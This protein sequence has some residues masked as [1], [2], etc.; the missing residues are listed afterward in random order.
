MAELRKEQILT[1]QQK[2]VI[3]NT[4]TISINNVKT[5]FDSMEKERPNWYASLRI[6]ARELERRLIEFIKELE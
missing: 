3:K 1:T 5:L 4:A 2:E 6:P